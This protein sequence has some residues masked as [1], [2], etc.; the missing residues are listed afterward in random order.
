[1]PYLV[2]ARCANV[3]H[4]GE[5]QEVVDSKLRHTHPRV[6]KQRAA[7]ANLA[8]AVA[9]STAASVAASMEETEGAEA[10][11]AA[12][13]GTAL[14]AS[15][16]QPVGDS[17]AVAAAAAAAASSSGTNIQVVQVLPWADADSSSSSGKGE[18]LLELDHVSI[19]TPDGGLALVQNLSL[20]V[21]LEMGTVCCVGYRGWCH[22]A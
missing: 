1:M 3:W 22:D 17:A 4:A 11:T 18:V 7:A 2:T 10:A 12:G 13:A 6:Q 19:N 9:A 15:S 8:A 5:F 14:Q 16:R 21:R 20:K